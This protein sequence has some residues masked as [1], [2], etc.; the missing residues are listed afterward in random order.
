MLATDGIY[1]VG[2]NPIYHPLAINKPIFTI[3][4]G[5]TTIQKDAAINNLLYPEFVYLGDNFNIQIEINANKLNGQNTVLE[6]LDNNNK[7]VLQQ[8]ININ[9][10]NFVYNTNVTANANKS[11]ILALIKFD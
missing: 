9:D 7:I 3:G 2:S 8:T 1:N 10:E 11:G 4:L 5:D 6:V